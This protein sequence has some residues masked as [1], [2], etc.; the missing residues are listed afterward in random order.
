MKTTM[1]RAVLVIIA[2]MVVAIGL[3]FTAPPQAHAD[4]IS[5]LQ[6]LASYGIYPTDDDYQ[7]LLTWGY[8][9]CTDA[10]IGRSVQTS[11]NNVYGAPENHLSWAG[12]RKMVEAALI[13]LC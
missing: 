8:E 10:R 13:Y 9:V 1:K 12:A 5:Y 4:E 7:T 2:P 3:L 11:I 6:V